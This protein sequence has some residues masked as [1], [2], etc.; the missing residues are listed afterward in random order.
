VHER[1]RDACS[2]RPRRVCGM[3]KARAVEGPTGG[4]IGWCRLGDEG[5]VSGSPLAR[6]QRLACCRSFGLQW[7]RSGGLQ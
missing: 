2:R 6:W 3:V 7:A 1:E 4:V 5:G